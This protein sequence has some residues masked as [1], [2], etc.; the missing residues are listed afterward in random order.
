MNLD[1]GS[2]GGLRRAALALHALCDVDREWLLQ[3]LPAA[4]GALQELLIELRELEMPADAAIIRAALG[5]AAVSIHVSGAQAASLSL[6]LAAEP[7]ALQGQLLATLNEAERLSVLAEWPE[8][9][10]LP[11]ANAEPDWT[12]ALREALLQSWRETASGGARREA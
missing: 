3:R 6:V 10:P 12:D 5:E 9:Q 2:Q 7:P 4:R 1:V 11:P 8:L